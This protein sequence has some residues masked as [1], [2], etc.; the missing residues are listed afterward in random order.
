[1]STRVCRVCAGDL[2]SI[3]DL[4]NLAI[5]T[6]PETPNAVLS[7]AP[8][9]FC[10]CDRCGLVQLRH[11]V[12]PERLF[13]D[14]YWYR[15]GVN[16]TMRAELDDVVEQALLHTGGRLDY[17]DL[18]CDIGANDGT[19]LAAYRKRAF[20]RDVPRIAFEPA[21]NL[22]PALRPHCE[23]LVQDFFPNGLD[24]VPG[25]VGR[26]KILT[27]IACFY[28]LDDPLV[29]VEQVAQLLHPEGVWVV[30]FQDLD[31]MLMATA[32]DNICHE[33]VFYPSLAAI[34]RMIQP[35]GLKV[36]DAQLRAINGGSYRLTIGYGTHKPATARVD[37]VRQLEA[38]CEDWQTLERF[39]WRVGEVRNQI[40]AAIDQIVDRGPIDVYGASTKFNTLAQYCGLDDG[41]IRQAWER[42][43]E[44][45]GRRTITGIPIVDEATGR[46]DPPV[47]LLA[48][49]WQFR[50][51]IL[52]RETDYLAGGGTIL[53]P[54]PVVDV[55]QQRPETTT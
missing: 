10:R 11:T 2:Q 39:A 42:S 7:R 14:Q 21:R 53:F 25:A 33:H 54:L 19:L 41:V 50:E 36:L 48:G 46:A 47:A 24:Q 12:H 4:G 27:S 43:P 31:Q 55:V 49:I 3:L 20:C 52:Q 8:L 5:S 16:E 22:W 28:D 44:K 6:F 29:F 40:Q 17:H 1:M 13:R 23:V 26:V 32:F 51:S 18:V 30:Q 34:E 37:E 15:S 9:D 38:G 45:V 35:Y